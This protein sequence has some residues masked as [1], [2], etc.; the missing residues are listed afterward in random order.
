MSLGPTS[1]FLIRISGVVPSEK[2]ETPIDVIF[3]R[4]VVIYFDQSTQQT[5]FKNF[6]NL[7]NQGGYLFFGHSETL[8][9][10]DTK[11]KNIGRTV[12]VKEA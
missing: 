7:Q 10:F 12:Y 8:K 9:G 4:N 3:C 2:K 6:S 5:L 1:I 11:Y